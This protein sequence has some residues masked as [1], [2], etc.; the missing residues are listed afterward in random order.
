MCV[1][2]ASGR[3]GGRAHT[4]LRGLGVDLDRGCAWLHSA[5]HNPLRELADRHGIGY[6]GDPAMAYCIDGCWCDAADNAAVT[7]R[8][9]EAGERIRRAGGQ[10]GPATADALLDTGAPHTPIHA[11]LLT[12]INGVE[13]GEYATAEAAAED[14]SHEDWVVHDGLGRL[15]EQLATGLDIRRECPV[16]RIEQR[17]DAVA[18]VADGVTVR[19]RCA[20]VTV[21]T[22]VL[23]AGA[24]EFDPP[25]D[26]ER[27]GALDA[28]PMGRAEKVA[29]RF[30]PDP[31]G[32]A[33]NT[34]VTIQRGEEAM[35]FHLLA[36]DD[37]L[38]VGY[39]GGELARFV[40]RAD[41]PEVLEWALGW[42]ADGFGAG[43][44]EAF[45]RGTRTTWL[46]DPL[47]RG[48]YSAA[49]PDGGHAQR[50]VLAR[51][52]G[53]RVLFAGEATSADRFATVD[54][55]WRSGERA[56]TEAWRLIEG[57]RGADTV[58]RPDPGD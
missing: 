17:D 22:G 21:S 48:G 7:A 20:I 53:E 6:L 40:A 56:A 30:R 18:V 55:A 46:D 1:L 42:L 23:G 16:R 31:F 44:R 12:A 35:G 14:D 5:G 11:Y 29:L 57:Q 8:W 37:R 58:K 51:P 49:R 9:H 27:R 28:V 26:A 19:A 45:V 50:G 24:I 32:L 43:V 25:L 4:S 38:A 10:G 15:V 13:P 39:A 2:E 33:D 47:V 36:G 54:G 34:Y 41:E 52:H 3:V